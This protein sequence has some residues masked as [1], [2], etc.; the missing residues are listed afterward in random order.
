MNHSTSPMLELYRRQGGGVKKISGRPTRGALGEKPS[1]IGRS[2]QPHRE[3][4]QGANVH[5]VFSVNIGGYYQARPSASTIIRILEEHSAAILHHHDLGVMMRQAEKAA[6]RLG[7]PQ[8]YTYH[9][10]VDV[11]VQYW[12]MQMFRPLFSRT[13]VDYC[14]TFD[15]IISPSLN[16]AERIREEGVRTPSDISRTPWCLILQV[17]PNPFCDRL[18]SWCFSQKH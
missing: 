11:L 9:M 17:A 14:N 6:R 3:V 16:L 18:P 8:V 4:W 10:P 1:R 7:L 12:P 2:G 5:R 15:V 13:I